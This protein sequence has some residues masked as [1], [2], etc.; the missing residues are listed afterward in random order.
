MIDPFV[1]VGAAASAV[2]F[3][4]GYWVANRRLSNRRTAPVNALEHALERVRIETGGKGAALFDTQG[5]LIAAVGHPIERE[6]TGALVG[7]LARVLEA[8]RDVGLHRSTTAISL[9]DDNGG[10]MCCWPLRKGRE[11]AML[12]MTGPLRAPASERNLAALMGAMLE[13]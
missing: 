9:H 7:L 13:S 10:A 11:S 6:A 12:A 1:L 4:A 5:F 2:F 3:S 8:S